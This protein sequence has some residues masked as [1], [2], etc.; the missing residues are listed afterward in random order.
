MSR[1]RPTLYVPLQYYVS[2][3]FLYD[4]YPIKHIFTIKKNTIM[5]TEKNYKG[6]NDLF[7]KTL[8]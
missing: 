6:I 3:Y 5:L 7:F 1:K 8:G 2:T 4:W